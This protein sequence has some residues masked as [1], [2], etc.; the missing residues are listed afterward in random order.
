M[1]AH[2]LVALT[3]VQVISH[4]ESKIEIAGNMVGS[5]TTST[6]ENMTYIT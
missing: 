5:V 2:L 6:F 3:Y 1:G 4:V